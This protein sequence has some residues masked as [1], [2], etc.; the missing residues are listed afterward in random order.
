MNFSFVDL[1]KN[2][3]S[4][5]RTHAGTQV[6][7]NLIEKELGTVLKR[8]A[9]YVRNQYLKFTS[10][11]EHHPAFMVSRFQW[12]GDIVQIIVETDDEIFKYIDEGTSIRYATMTP[13][14]VPKTTPGSLKSGPGAGGL[15]Y[16]SRKHPRPGIKARKISEL[17]THNREIK[18]DQ[19][20]GRAVSRVVNKVWSG[21]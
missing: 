4:K 5:H 2:T 20:L 1:S 7:N 8:E 13:D 15:A 10:T 14:F 3:T 6:V 18:F 16:V 19:N 11:W 21:I 9:N 12:S 17:I